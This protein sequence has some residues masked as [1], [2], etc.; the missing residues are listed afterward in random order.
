MSLK[1]AR[2]TLYAN[3][4]RQNL[5]LEKSDATQLATIFRTDEWRRLRELER[6]ATYGRDPARLLDMTREMDDLLCRFM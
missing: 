3:L 4:D 1:E 2:E 6:Q 5:L